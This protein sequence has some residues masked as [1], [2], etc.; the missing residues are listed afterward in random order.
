MTGRL[1]SF[2]FG[3]KGSYCAQNRKFPKIFLKVET[4]QN[5]TRIV[6]LIEKNNLDG[7]RESK[8][9]QGNCKMMRT[10]TTDREKLLRVA[11]WL[12]RPRN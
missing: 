7:D 2:P 11:Q 8:T 3:K 6:G 12:G 5:L 10:N 4:V 9:L 1:C